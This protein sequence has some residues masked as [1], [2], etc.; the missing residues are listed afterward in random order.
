MALFACASESG[1]DGAGAA[2]DGASTS[3]G[4]AG[5]TAPASSGIST[6][7]A[8][9][10][11]ENPTGSGTEAEDSTET[12]DAET[13]TGVA[14]DCATA[15]LPDCP[16]SPGAVSTELAEQWLIAGSAVALDV[17][18]ADAFEIEHVAGATVVDAAELRATVDGVSGQVA[19]P[20]E[21]QL[22]FEAAGLE[23]SDPIVMYGAANDTATAR[24]VWT[25]A[26]Y[27]HTGKVW[28]L[29]G[30][31]ATWTEQGRATEAGAA[32]QTD[33][34]YPPGLVEELRVDAQWVRDHLDDASVTLVDA[35]SAKEF[36]GG[37]IPGAVSVDW[38]RN[39]GSNGLFLPVA[40]LAEL[41]GEPPMAETLVVYCQTGSRASI[42]WL[43]LR[44]LGYPDV[45]IYDGSWSE[46][47]ADPTN[48]QES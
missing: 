5:T 31:L 20:L 25:L 23:P 24:V 41:Y 12:G 33:S 45:R 2:T 30:G 40:D 14:E 42:D 34:A 38:V 35:R 9:S 37:H 19:P 13:S 44:M 46:W 21:A 1:D 7:G 15:D 22:V 39:L 11:D 17:R 6:M 16:P 4:S 8:T 36:D 48:P 27:G 43:A 47:S 28:M 18:G 29:D 26:Y 32:G 3:S 10:G